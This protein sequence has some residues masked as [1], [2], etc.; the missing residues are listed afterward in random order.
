MNRRRFLQLSSSVLAGNV[1]ATPAGLYAQE[2]ATRSSI[3]L[4]E[5]ATAAGL[6]FVVRNGATETNT[7][8]ETLPGGLAVIDFDS[9]GW[10]DL[11]CTNGAALPLAGEGKLGVFPI[12]STA[13]I[14][15]EVSPM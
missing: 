12:G 14:A 5:G 13:I 7:Q 4:V 10:P 1:F 3:V 6:D 2:P 15:M 8:V 9:D 11:V